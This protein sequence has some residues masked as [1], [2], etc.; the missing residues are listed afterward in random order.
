M[1][2]GVSWQTAPREVQTRRVRHREL[3]AKYSP[4]ARGLK[5]LREWLS[6]E[7]TC[8]IR[9]QKNTST[10]SVATAEKKYRIRH[11]SSANIDELDECRRSPPWVGALSQNIHLVAR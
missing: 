2:S 8:A 7:A 1:I 6:P 5:L 10:S 11:G 9:L 3:R 4:E